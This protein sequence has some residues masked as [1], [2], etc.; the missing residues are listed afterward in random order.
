MG[1][2]KLQIDDF[3]EVTFELIAIHS[4]LEDYRL[5][6]F[7]NQKLPI[8]LEKNKKPIEVMTKNGEVCFTKFSYFDIDLDLDWNLFQNKNEIEIVETNNQQ[9]LFM[10]TEM[11]ISN[12][13]YM[14]P[15]F[16]KVDFFLKIENQNSNIN[17]L[18]IISKIK[19]I[20]S[21]STVYLVENQ[22]IKSKNNLIFQ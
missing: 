22:N 13:I 6:F 5:A 21:I 16:K 4:T 2:F 3:D 10:Y 9:N 20:K 19:K 15:E 12:T 8:L 11:A 14:L 18:E 17:V 1:V 7:L